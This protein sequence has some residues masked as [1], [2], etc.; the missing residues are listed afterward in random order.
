MVG[1]KAE[2][3]RKQEQN[4][5]TESVARSFGVGRCREKAGDA[6]ER[7]RDRIKSE[8]RNWGLKRNEKDGW[9]LE[10]GVETEKRGTVEYRDVG[11]EQEKDA[12]KRHGERVHAMVGEENKKRQKKI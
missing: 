11:N 4:E 3:R 2:K 12:R 8:K 5:A 1:K 6:R 7:D 10:E 9:M